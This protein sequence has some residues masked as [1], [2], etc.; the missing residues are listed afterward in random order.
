MLNPSESYQM[1]KID[2]NSECD[3][4]V[5]NCLLAKRNI[6]SVDLCSGVIVAI[7]WTNK[8]SYNK[9]A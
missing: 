5:N 2:I 6:N 9:L 8:K 1:V 4:S 7:Y 3:S